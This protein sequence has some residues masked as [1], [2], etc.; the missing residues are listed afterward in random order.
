MTIILN[1]VSK[2]YGDKVALNNFR[3]EIEWGKCYA[4][5]GPAG[6]GKTTA[7]KLF[8]GLEKPDQGE[9][10]R[11]GDYKYP[12]LHSAYVSQEGSLNPKKNALDNVRAAHRFL[13]KEKP[14]E[15]LSKFIE[16]E[17]LLL[18]VSELTD[19]EKRFVE[20]VKASFMV[21]DFIVLD[22]PFYGMTKEQRLAAIEFLLDFRG[23]RPTIIASRDESD[24]DFAKVIHIKA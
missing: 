6:C 23:S 16:P 12:T 4:F 14:R 3:A 20:L 19:V 1:N 13:G 10:A 22:E 8:M 9:V 21:A 17:Q 7:L 11:M 18:K 15:I 2:S 5:V 24:L